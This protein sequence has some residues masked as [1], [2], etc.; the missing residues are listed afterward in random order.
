[1]LSLC[2][3]LVL[4]A[5]AIV[6]YAQQ[7]TVTAMCSSENLLPYKTFRDSFYV[8]VSGQQNRKWR[9]MFVTVL[10]TNR[11]SLT[12]AGGDANHI[13][14]MNQPQDEDWLITNTSTL[15]IDG[16]T[17]L[18]HVY[19]KSPREA[20]IEVF[21]HVNYYLDE[22]GCFGSTGT[23]L[24]TKVSVGG[25]DAPGLQAQI[26]PASA[27][28]PHI[29]PPTCSQPRFAYHI[30]DVSQDPFCGRNCATGVF[31]LLFVACVGY[32]WWAAG[33]RMK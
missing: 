18:M 9:N 5:L 22:R 6:V 24:L 10:V 31:L 3:Y 23:G 16:R 27:L 8:I 15:T 19:R 25:L 11:T 7:A 4:G 12:A 2:S 32:M 21:V 13:I 29:V 17:T 1:M 20:A 30:A 26:E 14:T 28:C 33:V